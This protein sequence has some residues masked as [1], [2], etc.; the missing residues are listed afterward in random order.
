MSFFS[1]GDII[2]LTTLAVG[3]TV[4]GSA[5]LVIGA[6]RRRHDAIMRRLKDAATAFDNGYDPEVEE[7]LFR[8]DTA[9]PKAE[10][11]FGR[12]IEAIDLQMALIGGIAT[13]RRLAMAGLALGLVVA[14]VAFLQFGLSPIVGLAL[15]IGIAATFAVGVSTYL[16]QRRIDA[17]LEAFPGAVDLVVR[18]IRAGLPVTQALESIATEIAD[19]VGSEFAR[20][21]DQL[22]IGVGLDQA[23]VDAVQRIRIPELRFFAVTLILQRETGGQLAEVL[24]N[25]SD[26]LRQRKAMKLKIKSMT[27][28][29]RAAAKI[30]GVLPFVAMASMYFINPEHVIKLFEPEGHNL[31]I[32]SGVSLVLGMLIIKKLMKVDA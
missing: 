12:R 19:P 26:I 30:V 5:A 32:Y 25:L 1:T 9:G 31:L 28:E 14:A 18:G 20:I 21:T 29:A 13:G 22:K 11:W 16:L 24:E 3:V 2:A 8:A 23:L 4:G 27:S 7:Q 10:T 6:R 17:F 15:L